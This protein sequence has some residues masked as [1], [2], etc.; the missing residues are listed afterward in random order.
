MCSAIASAHF[1]ARTAIAG[2]DL[3][4]GPDADA[5]VCRIVAGLAASMIASRQANFYV[6]VAVALAVGLEGVWRSAAP[7]IVKITLF[8]E[9]SLIT[10]WANHSEG[11]DFGRAFR[12]G[13]R[14]AGG[15]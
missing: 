14:P 10:Q 1:G 8:H 6:G 2:I 4:P 5:G 11:H 12:G 13:E 15:Q 9:D 7:A 3:V